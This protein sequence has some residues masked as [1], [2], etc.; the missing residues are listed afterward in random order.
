MSY[1]LERD[2]QNKKNQILRDFLLK[3]YHKNTHDIIASGGIGLAKII[4]RPSLFS[5]IPTN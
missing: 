1:S 5:W 2:F 4:E 3:N